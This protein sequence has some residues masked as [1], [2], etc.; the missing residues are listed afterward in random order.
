MRKKHTLK[1]KLK[2]IREYD[3]NILGYRLLAKKHSVS[4]ST[5]RRW[6]DNYRLSGVD[7]LTAGKTKQTYPKDFKLSVLQ[8]RLK[9]QLSYKETAKAFEIVNSS[10]IAQWQASYDKYGMV[11]LKSRT[12]GRPTAPMKSKKKRQSSKKQQPIT[13]EERE[14][15]EH[16]RAKTRKL[17]IA[18]ALEKKLQSLAQENQTKK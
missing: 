4:E 5:L 15:L 2:I 18:I 9:H 17:E 16:L 8:Y 3:E 11:G 7:G 6:I 14:E 10:L 12:E 13:N 1:F